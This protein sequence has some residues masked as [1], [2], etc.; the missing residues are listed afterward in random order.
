VLGATLTRAQYLSLL[1]Q[2][3]ATP[4]QFDV[5][6]V[7]TVAANLDISEDRVAELQNVLRARRRQQAAAA[8]LLPPPTE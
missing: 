1:E 3:L 5:A 8:P 2:G 4:D 6:D 7:A